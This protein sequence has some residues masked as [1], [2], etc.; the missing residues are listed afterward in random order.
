MEKGKNTTL[1]VVLSVVFVLLMGAIAYVFQQQDQAKAEAQAIVIQQQKEAERTKAEAEAKRQAALEKQRKEAELERLRKERE[2]V[3]RLKR[4]QQAELE[5]LRREKEEA[6]RLKEEAVRIARE[7]ERKRQE[8]K[9]IQREAEA[10]RLRANS[11]LVES[12][13]TRIGPHDKY[14]SRGVKLEKVAE[15]VRQ[16]RANY[17]KFYKRD[18]EDR[19]DQFFSSMK[20][21]ALLEKMVRRGSI[22]RTVKRAILYDYPLIR[23]NVYKHRVDI[24]LE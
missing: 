5:R 19:P 20:N 24:E 18:P 22:S 8:A 16:D 21:R 12:Y 17:Y 4:E 7:E 23:V 6:Q 1:I 15:I 13:V 10:A 11:G 3:E 14:S 9:R 2:E